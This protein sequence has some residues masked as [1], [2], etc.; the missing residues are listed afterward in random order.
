VRNIEGEN[1]FSAL[2]LNIVE[3]S[4]GPGTHEKYRT[5]N[6]GLTLMPK[7][8]RTL[9]GVSTPVGN[10]PTAGST[11]INKKDSALSNLSPKS[12]SG[13]SFLNLALG[14]G[15]FIQGDTTGGVITLVSYGATAGLIGWEMAL[16][17]NDDL[18][19]IPGTVGLGVAGFAVVYGFIRPILYNRDHT[20]V[21]IADRTNITLVR[22]TRDEPTLRLSYILRF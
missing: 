16:S 9:I 17:Y 3:A 13:Y 12:V 7:I 20:L 11:N 1:Y 21:A 6:D 2:I 15:S 8:A 18:A 5:V 19:G 4:Q 14:L 10:V 22:G